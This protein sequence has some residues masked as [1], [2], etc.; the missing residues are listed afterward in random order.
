M[1]DIKL[2][3][4]SLNLRRC[5]TRTMQCKGPTIYKRCGISRNKDENFCCIEELECLKCEIAEDVLRNMI[6][7]DKY[8]GETTEKIETEI[9]AT[10]C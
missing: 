2:P 9:T 1:G 3:N 5:V 8:E 7:E 10:C 4:S 6:N